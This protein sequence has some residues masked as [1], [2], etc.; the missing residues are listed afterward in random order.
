MQIAKYVLIEMEF[1]EFFPRS[2]FELRNTTGMLERRTMKKLKCFHGKK[3]GECIHIQ[4]NKRNKRVV[5]IFACATAAYTHFVR[6]TR[7]TT[8]T[9]PLR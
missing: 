4:R 9:F 1:C 5:Q 7:K 3:K 8:T 2:N 6:Q